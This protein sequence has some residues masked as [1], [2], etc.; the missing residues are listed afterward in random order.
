ME[1]ADLA[2]IRRTFAA[3]WPS[4][5]LPSGSA[6]VLAPVVP[7]P[8][9]PFLLLERRSEGPSVFA[10]Q[11]GFPGGRIEPSDDGPLAAALREAEEEVGFRPADVDIVGHLTELDN[12]IGR[13]VV[14]FVGIVPLDAVPAQPAGPAEVAE[15]LLVPLR[16]L[17]TPGTPARNAV[18]PRTYLPVRYESREA[19]VRE[20]A[21]HYWHLEEA[22]GARRAVLWGL[23]GEMVARML[24]ALWGWTPPSPPRA[25]HGR[26]GLLP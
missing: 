24:H 13:R 8:A 2:L 23:T 18:P 21:L 10:G 1:D 11:L 19:P 3:P 5:P 15:L 25:V 17:L 22:A 12:H 16:A 7:T 20:R 9:G 14:A 26:D 4:H 6:A